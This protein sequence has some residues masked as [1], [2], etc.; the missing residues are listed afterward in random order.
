MPGDDS[1]FATLE[2]AGHPPG[3]TIG[4]PVFIDLPFNAAD[5]IG[6]NGRIAATPSK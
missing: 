5:A 2:H 3:S 6:E 1:P 4:S